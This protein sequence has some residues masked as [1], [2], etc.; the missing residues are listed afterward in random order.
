MTCTPSCARPTASMIHQNAQSWLPSLS[1]GGLEG[2]SRL[3]SGGSGKWI[4]RRAGRRDWAGRAGLK[5]RTHVSSRARPGVFGV[6]DHLSVDHIGQTT[7]QS[8][9]GFHRCF[10]VG[11]SAAVVGAAFGVV[12]KLDHGH[13]VQDPVDARFPA[14]DRRWRSCSPED[15][16]SGAVP[17]QE[18][19]CPSVANRL[20]S[21]TSPSSLAAPEGPMPLRSRKV[22]AVAAMSSVSCVLP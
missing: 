19:K 15:A 20:M 14:R 5:S 12:T 8:T 21:V 16:S 13:D 1:N 9:P 11:E 17:F 6:V 7:F 10:A 3:A 18:A 2:C 4:L 22:L